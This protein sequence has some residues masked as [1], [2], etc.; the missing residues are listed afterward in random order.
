MPQR[1]FLIATSLARLICKE[2][3]VAG[4]VSE[5]Y[6]PAHPDRDQLVSLE[7]GHYDLVL[8]TTREGAEAEERTELPRS[9]AEALLA[10]A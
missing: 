3:G 6:F 8:I 4:Q 1:R 5:G 2:Q 9:Q 7:P 10:M